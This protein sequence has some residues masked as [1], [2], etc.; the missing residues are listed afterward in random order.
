MSVR[1]GVSLVDDDPESPL[2]GSSSHQAPSDY[3]QDM[4]AHLD[5]LHL[6]DAV[7]SEVVASILDVTHRATL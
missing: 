5:S 3:I 2:V 1:P 6:P 4:D 7:E